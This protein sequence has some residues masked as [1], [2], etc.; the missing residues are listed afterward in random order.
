MRSSARARITHD[1]LSLSFD[2]FRHALKP[3]GEKELWLCL[4]TRVALV[5]QS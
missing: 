3:L 1:G 5:N 4:L 2:L